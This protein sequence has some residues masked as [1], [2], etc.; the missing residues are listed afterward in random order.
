M[1]INPAPVALQ[2]LTTREAITDAVLRALWGID[3]NDHALWTSAWIRDK[4]AATFSFN[5][6]AMIGMDAIDDGIFKRIGP[7]A[8]THA[9]SNVRVDV[10]EGAD[11]AYLTAYQLAQAYRAGEGRDLK[12]EH[13]QEGALCAVDL[14][15]DGEVW[16]IRK[17][18]VEAVWCDGQPSVF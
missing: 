2:S 10:P 3:T 12:S 15:A 8:T 11:T 4:A 17:W 18:A 5:G 14:V 16:R 13:F 9:I 1:T 7:A 6:A